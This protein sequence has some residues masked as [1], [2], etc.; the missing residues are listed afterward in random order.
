MILD[1]AVSVVRRF[2]YNNILM[3]HGTL[4][5]DGEVVVTLCGSGEGQQAGLR[6]H[7]PGKVL[8]SL[9]LSYSLLHCPSPLV[10]LLGC[11]GNSGA[12][13]KFVVSNMMDLCTYKQGV[14]SK[15]RYMQGPPLYE[16]W[17]LERGQLLTVPPL[18]KPRKQGSRSSA[19]V[20]IIVITVEK[21][22]SALVRILDVDLK[23]ND[24]GLAPGPPAA[25]CSTG[26]PC[27]SSALQPSKIAKN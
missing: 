26:L 23:M 15:E 2:C 20:Q 4:D 25:H 3:G 1:G 9:P 14:K 7:T 27:Q 22:L 18:V 12:R 11:S 21:L 16:L 19:V 10:S 24:Y 5:Q 17:F 13:L 6:A 8:G